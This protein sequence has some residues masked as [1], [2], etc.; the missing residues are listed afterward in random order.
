MS[1]DIVN[2]PAVLLLIN[3]CDMETER[4][5]VPVV[6]IRYR[7]DIYWMFGRPFGNLSN[8]RHTQADDFGPRR[9]DSTAV[10]T[11]RRTNKRTIS[12]RL[13]D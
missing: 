10:V 1:F 3:W 12:S 8:D 6:D 11:T 2:T 9:T 4:E 5:G 7:Y 13:S